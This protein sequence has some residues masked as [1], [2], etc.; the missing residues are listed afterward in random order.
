M[1]HTDALIRYASV[2]LRPDPSR[3]IALP[4]LPG[5]EGMSAGISR[6]ESVVGRVLALTE[7]EVA[8]EL[9]AVRASFGERHP[10]LA[11]TFDRNFALVAH[12]VSR[13]DDITAERTQLIG[14]YFTQEFS[15]EGAALF[16]PSI[17][18]DPDPKNPRPGELPFVMSLRAVGE[19]HVSTI[20]F[21]TGRFGPG[22]SV[23]IDRPA[24]R[25]GTGTATAAPMTLDALRM[26]LGEQG[27]APAA[28]GLLRLLPA[29]FTPA[30]LD[31]ALDRNLRDGF[32]RSGSAG[33]IDRIRRLAA[34]NYDLT[35]P[36]ELDLSARV[37]HPTSPAE[38]RGLEDARFTRFAEDDG[39]VTY[40]ATYTAFDGS[41][42]APHLIRTD[43][44]RTFSMRQLTGRAATNKGMALFPRRVGGTLWA[45]CRWD[46]ENLSVTRSDDALHWQEPVVVQR[47]QH[48]WD[49]VQLG[50]CGSPIETPDGWLAI[51]H[52][53]GPARTYAL[54]AMLLDLDDPFTVLAVLAEPLMAVRPSERDG[55][56]PNVVYSCGGLVR[57][58]TILLPYGAADATV[59]FAL[60]D[61]PGLLHR[62]RGNAV[63]RPLDDT[64]SQV[65]G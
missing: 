43:D 28:E 53:V 25:L 33:L 61:L 52:G 3:V 42:I 45:L 55:Y 65:V 21:R 24:S 4:F 27:D 50:T 41:S 8:A 19:G 1:R 34:S 18:P 56:V 59:G 6:A 16:N 39:S 37:L 49:L 14:A 2:E 30:D 38:D 62:L 64:V 32:G 58:D 54:G 40:Y 48:T 47:P 20:E 23:T 17:V 57:D 60:I 46:R 22:D 36:A 26:S 13:R 9:S 29:Q 10:D 12:H 11:A 5:Q 44:F 51:T 63:A 15:L 35:F 31:Q 7:D